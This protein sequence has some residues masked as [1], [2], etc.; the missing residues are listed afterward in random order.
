MKE[1]QNLAEKNPD[2]VGQG[3]TI[4]PD[5]EM[6]DGFDSSAPLLKPKSGEIKEAT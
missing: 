3:I 5:F 1:V 2:N 4:I 6:G